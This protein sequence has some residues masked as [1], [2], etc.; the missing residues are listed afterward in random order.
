MEVVDDFM[1]QKDIFMTTTIWENDCRSWFKN[2]NTGKIS[3]LWP[4][5]GLSKIEAVALQRF[6]DF[7]VIYATKNRDLTHYVRHKD[8]GEFGVS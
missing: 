5:S 6:E 7:Y 8:N 1:E 3:E 4:G 2:A